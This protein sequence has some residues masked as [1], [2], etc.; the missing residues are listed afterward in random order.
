MQMAAVAASSRDMQDV[1]RDVARHLGET[2]E[3]DNSSVHPMMEDSLTEEPPSLAFSIFDEDSIVST[4]QPPKR[5]RRDQRV[6]NPAEADVEPTRATPASPG[7][8]LPGSQRALPARTQA[9]E[10]PGRKPTESIK[11]T[12]YTNKGRDMLKTAEA[13]YSD[14]LLWT[15]R[16]KKRDIE[17]W[18]KKAGD[19]TYKIMASSE[20]ERD[21][22]SSALNE[23]CMRMESRY[24]LF[25][26]LS[27][28]IL[29]FVTE[30]MDPMQQENLLS[31][32]FGV[33]N[34]ILVYAAT[35]CLK[36]IEQVG[37]GRRAIFN[38]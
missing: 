34:R 21:E 5:R 14:E 24:E 20:P 26:E 8:S 16:P 30:P 1:S 29:K 13:K 15:S 38:K 2:F 25:G 37:P 31:L 19:L 10:K 18:L 4:P 27:K 7:H 3:D 33:L 9:V 12:E 22:I 28:D 36:G 23:V 11:A 32:E 17:S 6:A 35:E